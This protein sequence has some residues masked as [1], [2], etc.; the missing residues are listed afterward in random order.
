MRWQS[1][2]MSDMHAS[3]CLFS[4]ETGLRQR[5]FFFFLKDPPPTEIYPLPLPAALPICLRRRRSGRLILV[6]DLAGGLDRAQVAD[7][8]LVRVEGAG[9]VRRERRQRGGLGG[10][11]VHPPLEPLQ[12]RKSTRLNFSHLVIS[13]AVFCLK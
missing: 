6:R 4:K 12:D 2:S 10:P 11:D 13:Y 5:Y 8:A 1:P 9:R 3:A 7:A